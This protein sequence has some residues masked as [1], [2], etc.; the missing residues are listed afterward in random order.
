M[1]QKNTIEGTNEGL[2]RTA[3]THAK[4]MKGNG[5]SN[6]SEAWYIQHIMYPTAA[7]ASKT[8]RNILLQW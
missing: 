5:K 8:S 6:M 3:K 2:K 4:P 1:T 7:V